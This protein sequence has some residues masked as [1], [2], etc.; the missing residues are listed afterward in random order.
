[1][2]HSPLLRRA[3]ELSVLGVTGLLLIAT[4]AEPR[5]CTVATTRMEAKTSCAPPTLVDLTV[6]ATCLLT[7]TQGAAEAGLPAEGGL[8]SKEVFSGFA[9]DALG[10]DG[11]VPQNCIA[12][13]IQGGDRTLRINCVNDCS[14]LDAGVECPI[15]CSGIITPP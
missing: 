1:M 3:L 11:G 4:S 9:L 15:A 5:R 6:D 2:K 13:P 14:L 12:T 7:V 8:T 10:L